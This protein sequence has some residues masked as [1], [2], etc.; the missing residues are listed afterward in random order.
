M[1]SEGMV[2][3]ILLSVLNT[4]IK[5]DQHSA[6][7]SKPK[8]KEGIIKSYSLFFGL[9]MTEAESFT[10]FILYAKRIVKP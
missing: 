2:G 9:F 6:L 7:K 1:L 8:N 5:A 3:P 4:T 10:Y